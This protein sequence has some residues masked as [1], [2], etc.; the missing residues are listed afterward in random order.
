MLRYWST[1]IFQVDSSW[2][3]SVKCVNLSFHLGKVIHYL[4]AHWT[5]HMF[6]YLIHFEINQTAAACFRVIP[7]K[8]TKNKLPLTKLITGER[9]TCY[10]PVGGPYGEKL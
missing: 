7:L 10:L 5:V 9:H 2:V 1:Q 6:K 3:H 8:L 4:F